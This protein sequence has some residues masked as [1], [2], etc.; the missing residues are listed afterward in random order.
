MLA[1][2]NL[3]TQ[4]LTLQVTNEYIL[5]IYPTAFSNYDHWMK[6]TCNKTKRKTQQYNW[7][8]KTDIYKKVWE[9]NHSQK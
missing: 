9:N 2:C 7:Q 4:N 1:N 6:Y 5:H 3:Q 8:T